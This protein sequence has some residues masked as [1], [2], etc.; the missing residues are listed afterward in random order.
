MR[1][2]FAVFISASILVMSSLNHTAHASDAQ[3]DTV[4]L[5]AL[6]K[7]WNDAHIQGNADALDALWAQEL[8]VTVP[9]MRVLT[10]SDSLMFFRSGRMKFQRYET[11]DVKVQI[12]KDAAVVTG[13]LLRARTISGKE[14]VDDWRFTKVYIR[15]SGQWRVVAWH[16]S[17]SE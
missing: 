11:S 17:A 7:V 6:E 13:R 16:A 15:S 2:F 1:R 3:Q 4:Q 10:K 14:I 12:F 8:T 9:G 5:L